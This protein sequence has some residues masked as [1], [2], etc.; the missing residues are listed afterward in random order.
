LTEGSGNVPR[1]HWI[2]GNV[3]LVQFL[4]QVKRGIVRI[5]RAVRRG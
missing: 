2:F 4:A 1:P 3:P 5:G